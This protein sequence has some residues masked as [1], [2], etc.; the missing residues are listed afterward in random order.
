MWSHAHQ[1][2]WIPEHHIQKHLFATIRIIEY[3]KVK[4]IDDGIKQV[5]KLYLQHSVNITCIHA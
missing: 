1:R 3:W 2:Y 5:N 4:N